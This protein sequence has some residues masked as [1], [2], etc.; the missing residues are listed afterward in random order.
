LHVLLTSNVPGSILESVNDDYVDLGQL[1]GNVGNQNYEIPA[2]I[3]L[4]DFIAVV[5][6]C[7][8]FHV[9]FSAAEI[10]AG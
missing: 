8:P 2:D 4:E 1:K 3:V 6:Y 9:N 7:E 5:I 10:S